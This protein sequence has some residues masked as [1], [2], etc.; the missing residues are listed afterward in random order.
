MANFTER[1]I[2]AAKLDVRVYEEVEADT[3]AT[4][5]AVGVVLFA[6]LAGG[7][8]TAGLGAGGDIE[9]ERL[10][11]EG[12]DVDLSTQCSVCDGDIHDDA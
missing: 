10:V 3:D 7:I 5:Q 12:V 2:G 4:G 11:F 8:G 9:G 6:S 1:M